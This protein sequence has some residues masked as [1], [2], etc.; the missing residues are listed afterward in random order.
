MPKLTI[1]TGAGLSAES[2]VATFRSA[3]GLWEN[4]RIEEVCHIS[5]WKQNFEKVHAF[6]N[7]RRTQLATVEPNA[8]HRAIASWE[9]RYEATVLTQ[10]VDD[11]LERAG[12]RNA[13]HLH[14]RL[15]E[16]RCTACEHIWNIGH[17]EWRTGTPCPAE[18]C[19]CI[20]GVKPNIVFFG[21][22]APRYADLWEE[23]ESTGPDDVLIVIGTSGV[24]LPVNTLAQVH[25]GYRILNNLEPEPAI[26]EAQFEQAFY[27]PATKAVEEIDAALRERLG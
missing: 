7:A 22:M 23:F 8:A 19:G 25:E 24:V 18:G 2:G 4:H 20:R 16:L 17:T 27:M 13:I 15:Q 11:L 1:L 10:N 12:C 9:A 14:G 3:N 5:T 6:Y 26:D 21:E